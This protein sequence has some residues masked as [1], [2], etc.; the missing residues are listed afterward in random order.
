MKVLVSEKIHPSGME[1]LKNA[2]FEICGVFGNTK[3]KRS[4][5]SDS[6]FYF[7]ARAIK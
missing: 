1:I 3:F 6:K 4:A 7:V 2:G 5:K